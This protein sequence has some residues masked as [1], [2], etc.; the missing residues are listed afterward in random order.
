MKTLQNSLRK[1]REVQTMLGGQI[2]GILIEN[3]V[4]DNAT[5]MNRTRLKGVSAWC[6]NASIPEPLVG[7]GEAFEAPL[8]A[9]LSVAAHNGLPAEHDIQDVID[10]AVTVIMPGITITSTVGETVTAVTTQVVRDV[11]SINGKFD[12]VKEPF[13]EL[14]A[15][16]C[17]T[18]FFLY[19]YGGSVESSV[20][21]TIEFDRVA[22][23]QEEWLLL[24]AGGC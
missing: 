2:T 7:R 4:S 21:V 23:T 3:A 13:D 5:T 6:R 1:L 24:N 20:Q 15:L 22:I 14:D 10:A 17:G 16:M 9:I 18:N 19:T 8:V 11:A 12:V